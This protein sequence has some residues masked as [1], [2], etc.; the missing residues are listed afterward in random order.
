MK[1]DISIFKTLTHSMHLEKNY[2]NVKT[3]LIALK[4]NQFK[5]HVIRDIIMV[6]FLVDLNVELQNFH[7]AFAIRIVETHLHTT[8]DEYVQNELNILFGTATSN[9]TL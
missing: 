7:V 1:T 4:C 3:I 2:A 9:G 8:I 6:V 5:R